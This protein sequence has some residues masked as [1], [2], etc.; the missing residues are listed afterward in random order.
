MNGMKPLSRCMALA[1]GGSLVIA[2]TS[3]YAQDAAQKQERIEVTGSN[4]KRIDSETVS[5]VQV[6]TREEIERS[7]KATIADVLRDIPANQG[8]SYN[9][10]FTNSFSPGSSG[11]SLRGLGLKTTLTLVNGRRMANYGF[12]QNLQDTFV[13]LNSI[14]SSAVERV[15]ILKDGA[16]AI[17]GADAVAG[18]VN[19]I[20]RKD[21]KG[22]EIGSSG[23]TT[24]EGGMN[25]YRL[26]LSAG[27]G[28][29]ATDKFNV[30]GV[31][32]FY[33][34]DLLTWSERNATKDADFRGQAGGALQWSAG[35]GTY[36]GPIANVGGFNRLAMTP[37]PNASDSRLSADTFLEAQTGTVC[38][39]NVA[40]YLTLIPKTDRVGFLGK[41][42]YQIGADISAF[43]ELSLS[44]NKTQQ[45]FTPA[46]VR[47]TVITAQ[48][49]VALLPLRLTATNP[50]N[51][52]VTTPDG[53]VLA[54]ATR[55]INYAFRE[56]GGRDA[57][58]TT[59]SGRVLLGLKGTAGS[60]D[61]ET[62]IGAAK[63]DTSQ[64]NKNR[65]LAGISSDAAVLS[66]YNFQQPDPS[67]ALIN[68]YKTNLTRKATSELQF[69]DAKAN[70]EL[71]QLPAGAVSFATGLEYRKEKL[72]D[73]PDPIAAQLVT[74]VTNVGTIPVYQVVG[75]GGTATNGSR[76]NTA[77][78]GEFSIPI[79][80]TLESQIAVRY[81]K[82]SDFGGSTSPKLGFKWTPITQ[83][84]VRANYG[85][86]FRAPTL[87]EISPSTATF[88]TSVTDPL[89]KGQVVSI[90][91]I[92]NGNPDLK[93]ERSTSKTAGIVIEPNKD[94]SFGLGWYEIEIKDLIVGNLQLAVNKNAAR[95]PAY[96]GSVTRDT[97][98]PTNPAGPILFAQDKY[99][100]VD[101]TKVRGADFD[102]KIVLV[103]NGERGK[104]T[105]RGELT[106]MDKYFVST[107]PDTPPISVAG[108]NGSDTTS[109]L[110]R[111]RLN[112]SLDWD[113]GPWRS[114][115]GYR[116]VDS[117]KQNSASDVTTTGTAEPKPRDQVGAYEQFDLFLSYEG[118]K[119]LKISGSILN[120]LNRRPPFDP[121]YGSGVDFTLY[122]LRGRTYTLGATYT[123][124]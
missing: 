27:K 1:F 97:P 29:L 77:I 109:S 103:P 5:P 26:N 104:W 67:S 11:I 25:E 18:V 50:A 83:L 45:T 35:G 68:Q 116:Y 70:A 48:G 108:L 4:I 111:I 56:F 57:E 43:G 46:F 121:A 105:T 86:G 13:D 42:T 88:F 55:E 58:I 74:T 118:I 114:T 124:K 30:F 49:S 113:M 99:R 89:N 64:L 72:K 65:L 53:T 78:F 110:P 119:N 28:D 3:V 82:Y 6:I 98:T 112:L 40:P 90:P 41:G 52:N 115:L 44:H 47:G 59:D 106:Y 95:D 51:Q 93:A 24:S 33:H 75:Q 80:K 63:S 117:T 39:F 107:G 60:W 69:F 122:D 20:L 91:G 7:G 31:V 21:Y 102:F 34:R 76:S 61:Y 92:F 15:E 101:S 62:A 22:I 81:D 8:N 73:T 32:D 66:T 10:T 54:P 12:A 85:K 17:Y 16:S 37:C 71:F 100:N 9:E 84:A 36:R 38:A 120:A 87:P 96:A 14:P 2:S 23:G 123:F 19:I 94:V 79:L